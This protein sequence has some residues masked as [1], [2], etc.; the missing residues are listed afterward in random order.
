MSS[1]LPYSP[2]V[3]QSRPR[4]STLNI[5]Q[6]AFNLHA[7]KIEERSFSP[8][9][10]HVGQWFMPSLSQWLWLLLLLVL[11]AQPWRT[12]MVSADG[13]ACMHWRVG[14]WMLQ[15]HQI[16][17]SDVFSHTRFGQ[18]IVSKEWLSEIIFAAA[19]R[20]AGLYGLVVV[21]ALVIATA[22]AFLHRQL[23]REGNDV[24]VATVVVW[25]AACAASAHWLARPHVFSF[26]MAALWHDTLRR[27]ERNGNTRALVWALCVLTVLWVNLHG[28]YLAGFLVLGAYWFGAAIERDRRKLRALT[29]VG[30]LGGVASLLNPTGYKLHIHN[31]HFLRSDFFKN[32]LAEYGSMNFHTREATGFLLWLGLLFLT[33]ALSRPKLSAA[34]AIVLISWTYFALYAARNI[35]LMAIFTAPIVA[36]PLSEA[37]RNRWHTVAEHSAQISRTGRGWPVVALA[38]VVAIGYV[39]RPTTMPGDRWPVAAVEFIK[40]NR[41][42][43]AGNMFNQYMWGGYLMEVLPEH[44]VFVDGRAD[45]YGEPLVKE[46]D[47][48]TALRTNWLAVL[49][50]YDVRWTLMPADHRLNVALA[51]LPEW[52]PAFSN[53]TAVI[54]RRRQ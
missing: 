1:T 51:L 25:L 16:L 8:P 22:F 41:D 15:H 36:P 21:A 34:S 32:W 30:S 6:Q 47:A 39:P 13:D 43:F 42:Q 48:V 24:L 35:P 14:E 27:F 20:V 12:T 49:A 52:K 45:F 4:S 28:G 9:T 50:K 29:V 37:L 19:G 46:F 3:Y 54:L 17:R 40:Q 26:L 7:V 10:N 23:L 44:K 38:A 2:Y 31:V 33:L 11:L 5:W 18:P 53:E